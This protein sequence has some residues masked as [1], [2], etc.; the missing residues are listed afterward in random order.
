MTKRELTDQAKKLLEI[1]KKPNEALVIY[2]QVWSSYTEE[3]NEWDALYSLKSI[4]AAE[5]KQEEWEREVLAAFPEN[6][7][8]NGFYKWILF[9]RYV[10]L[11]KAIDLNSA[12]E[13]IK[14]IVE[15]STQNNYNTAVKNTFPCPYTI[16]VFN[17]LKAYKKP[18]FNINKIGFWITKLDPE[19]LNRKPQSYKIEGK[20]NEYASDFEEYYS[21][22]TKYLWETKDYNACINSC[23]E[24]LNL[25]NKFHYDNDIW[26]QRRIALSLIKLNRSEEA[27][28][29]IE[30]L[31]ENKAGQKWFIE[32]ELSE[33]Y[34]DDKEYG[35]ALLHASKA[36]LMGQDLDKKAGL[37][38]TIARIFTYLKKNENGK[39]HA[40]LVLA[41]LKKYTL[42][43]KS[44]YQKMFHHFQLDMDKPKDPN[45]LI[46]IC[47][48]IWDEVVFAGREKFQGKVYKIHGNGKSGNIKREDG[49]QFFFS[50]REVS[51]LKRNQM[52]EGAW[53]NFYLKPAT[54]REGNPTSHGENIMVVKWPIQEPPKSRFNI[55]DQFSGEVDGIVP[56][57]VFVRLREVKGLVHRSEIQIGEHES[58]GNHFQKGMKVR[59][60][61]IGFYKEK[62]SFRFVK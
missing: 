62:P 4:R 43:I 26:L 11:F 50:M 59:V 16:G 34:V 45:R 35:K 3:R 29:I 5:Q 56:Y 53:V 37:F 24:G 21:V 58:L 25:I 1:D 14:R 42:K 10:K 23:E 60:E 61:V 30:K 22:L 47:Q 33:I 31:L 40:E 20:T 17:L 6:E 27:E 19:K 36:A 2:Q 46:K 15:I 12:E 8:I 48:P 13:G 39:I 28:H 57:G 38:Y 32:K 44:E 55:G 18:N 49:A 52:L 41:I 54:D 9:D 7:K 51:N